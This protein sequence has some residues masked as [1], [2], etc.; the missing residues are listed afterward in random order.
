MLEG[1]GRVLTLWIEDSH[2]WRQYLIGHVMIADDEI[3]VMLFGLSYFVDC[4]NA[5][6]QHNY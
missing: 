4:L 5:A 1:V 2:S 3:N 6:V